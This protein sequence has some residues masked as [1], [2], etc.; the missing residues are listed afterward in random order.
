VVVVAAL[1]EVFELSSEDVEERDEIEL[2][3]L[4]GET[5]LAAAFLLLLI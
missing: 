5:R 4:G 1:V 3:D 2:G